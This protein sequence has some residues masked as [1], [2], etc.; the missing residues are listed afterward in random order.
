MTDRQTGRQTD[1][2]RH[3]YTNRDRQTY[4]HSA[5]RVRKGGYVYHDASQPELNAPKAE[6]DILLWFVPAPLLQY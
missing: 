6:E 1:G 5:Q 2:Q 4:I 3:R